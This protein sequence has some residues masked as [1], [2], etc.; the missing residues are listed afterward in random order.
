ML[1]RS[2]LQ[3]KITRKQFFRQAEKMKIFRTIQERYAILGIIPLNQT[4]PFNTRVLRGFALFGCSLVSHMVYIFRMDN[5]F[6]KF[7]EG[8]CSTFGSV[9]VLVCFTAIAFK[10]E[11]LFECI[12]KIE[13]LIDTSETSCSPH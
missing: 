4:I 1:D 12:G 3:N 9:I 10:K 11:L 8:I 6:M 7:V 2:S 5:D 13:E